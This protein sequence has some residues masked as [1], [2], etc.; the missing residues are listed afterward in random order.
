MPTPRWEG[1]RIR[2][3]RVTDS[4]FRQR[5]IAGFAIRESRNRQAGRRRLARNLPFP[6]GMRIQTVLCPL[7]FSGLDEQEIGIAL[8]VC[9]T[10]GAKLVLHHD[11]AAAEPGF[12]RV[13]EWS[14]AH[15]P[16]AMHDR[17]VTAHLQALLDRI[18]VGVPAEAAITS[19]PLAGTVL[20]LAERL[21][22]DVIVLGSHGW[23]SQDH[24]S[25]AERVIDRSPCPVLTFQERRDAPAFR[26][27][28]AA[29]GPPPR[30]VVP[31]DLSSTS[32]SAVAWACA[33]AREIEMRVDLLHVLPVDAGGAAVDH[34]QAAMDGLVPLDLVDEVS[35]H[36]RRGDPIDEI[37]RYLDV[38]DPAFVVLGEHSRGI[39]RH[40]FTRDTTR[41]LVRRVRCPAWV[42]P[43]SPATACR[44]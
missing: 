12:S 38:T 10:F 37:A 28:A 3:P 8:E 24:A 5:G 43:A 26:L 33:L 14:K 40:L 19:G 29:G 36:L 32:A 11:V 25:V 4:R 30:A 18:A 2:R 13:W 34:A 6:E 9:R 21:P 27:R 22:A 35:A 1:G 20:A 15:Q 17:E 44:E 31:T 16:S 23:S 42:V 41:A 7:D 39:F